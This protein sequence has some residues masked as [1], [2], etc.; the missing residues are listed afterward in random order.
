MKFKLSL[1]I[2]TINHNNKINKIISLSKKHNTNLIIIGDKKTPKKF[3]I[4]FGKF[5]DI[6]MQ[7]KFKSSFAKRCP[8]NS[9][10]RKNIGYLSAIKDKSDFI[11]ETDDD[12]LPDDNFFSDI[13]LSPDT[14]HK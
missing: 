13:N 9:Y 11:V 5:F 12:N 7:K 3:K 4:S 6:N 1:V 2:T 10:S 8:Y 14:K